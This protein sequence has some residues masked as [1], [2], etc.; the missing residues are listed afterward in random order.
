MINGDKK[1]EADILLL[2]ENE[3][4]PPIIQLLRLHFDPYL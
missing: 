4:E 1:F 3:E 2:S